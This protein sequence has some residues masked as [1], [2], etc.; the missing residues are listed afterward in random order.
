MDSAWPDGTISFA[1][2]I[3][4]RRK[5]MKCVQV[6]GQ[7]AISQKLNNV[8]NKTLH[9]AFEYVEDLEYR[10]LLSVAW[11]VRFWF[12]SFQNLT[13][14]KTSLVQYSTS[15]RWPIPSGCVYA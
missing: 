3:L 7:R 12:K 13:I 15:A 4:Q 2:V 14:H 9:L 10:L 8:C 1:V 11:V 5:V 6:N